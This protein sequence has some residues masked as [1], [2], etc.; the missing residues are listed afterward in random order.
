ME[1]ALRESVLKIDPCE[2]AGYLAICAIAKSNLKL[3]NN[4]I[5]DTVNPLQVTRDLWASAAREAD[6]T[7]FNIEIVC[8]DPNVH[9][10]RVE[11]RAADID[12]FPL[13]D[14]H[15]VVNRE[16]HPWERPDLRL[17]SAALNVDACVAAILSCL[18]KKPRKS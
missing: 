14:W 2:D 17:D 3:G 10:R 15:R 5:A 16:Y 18:T 12:N 6:A 1:A 13:P 11:T 9:Q 4:V 8:S 7:L